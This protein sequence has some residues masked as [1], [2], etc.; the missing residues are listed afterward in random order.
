MAHCLF[1]IANSQHWIFTTECSKVTGSASAIAI[2]NNGTYLQLRSSFYS[3]LCQEGSHVITVFIQWNTDIIICQFIFFCLCG[4]F[5]H[6]LHSVQRIFTISCF[7]TQ[8]QSIRTI[9][10]GV[11][12]IR[13]LCTGRTR[14]RNHRMEH[15][16]SYYYRF[17]SQNTLTD[18]QTLDAGDT[19]LRNFDAKVTTSYHHTIGYFQNLVDVIHTFLVFNLGNDADITVMSVQDFLY[20]KNILFVAH[21]RVCYEVNIFLDGIKDVI[22]VLLCQRR[23]VY[24]YTRYIDALAASQRSFILHL[25]H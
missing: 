19:F 12:N 14:I 10:N 5:R 11:S 18:K 22:A 2:G 4:N 13:H 9:I 1:F 17:L 23:K 25:A 20:I 15:L 24:A 3:L 6:G 8:H 16:G 7:T 21:K